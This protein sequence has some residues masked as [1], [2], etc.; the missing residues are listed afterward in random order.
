MKTKRMQRVGQAGFTLIELIIAVTV[1]SIL[2][3]AAI[4]LTAKMLDYKARTA[5][6]EEEQGIVEAAANYFADNNQLPS[7]IA[8]LLVQPVGLTTWTGPY[9]PGVSTDSLSGLTTYQVDGWSRP[10]RVTVSGDAWTLESAGADN[11]FGNTDDVTT[12]LNVTYLRRKE[13]LRRLEIVNQA[14][15]LY[16]GTWLGTDPLSTDWAT[17]FTQLVTRGYLPNDTTLR[18]DGW[19]T[20][21][22]ENPVG[23]SPVVQVQS[24]NL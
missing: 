11:T 7:S 13:T 12:V 15:T 24:T 3:G 23:V 8:D 19:G 21:F 22:D 1:L 20:D 16:N 14:I 2:A 17:A 5:T 18:T 10:Y 6:Q 9:L 4:P